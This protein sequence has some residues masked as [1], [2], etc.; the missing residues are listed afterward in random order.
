MLIGMVFRIIW[1]FPWEDIF[2][3]GASSAATEFCECFQVGV[4][5]YIPHDKYQFKCHSFSIVFQLLVLLPKYR[6]TT[7]FICTNRI[8]LLPL[9]WSYASNHCKR[10]LE[11][12]KLPYANEA[13][14]SQ[15]LGSHNFWSI[16]PLLKRPPRKL[17][18]WFDIWSCFLQ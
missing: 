18:I 1:D 10:V 15:K 4:D 3:L 13:K 7:F 12:T 8:N 14:E 17:E 16:A 9:K 2:K 11:A 5:V 6:G